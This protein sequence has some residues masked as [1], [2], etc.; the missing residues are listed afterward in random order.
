MVSCQIK[1]C[2]LANTED[3]SRDAL[4]LKHSHGASFFA[5]RI[6]HGSIWLDSISFLCKPRKRLVGE[7]PQDK[8]K[9]KDKC[10]L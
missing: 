9:S 1:L 7:Q 10:F 5:N 2:N 6:L 8:R 3:L 4:I